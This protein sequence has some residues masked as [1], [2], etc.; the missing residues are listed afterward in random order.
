MKTPLHVLVAE[1]E[2]GDVL[3][4]ERAFAKAGV[5]APV[6]VAADGQEVLD[7][8]EGVPPFNNPV[9]YPL[10]DLLLLDLHLPRVNGF[11]VLTRIR[12]HP[13]LSQ[14]LVVILSSSN[15]PEEIQRA[16]ALG[17]NSYIVKPQDPTE[18]VEVVRGLQEHWQRI[19][20]SDGFMPGH[21]SEVVQHLTFGRAADLAA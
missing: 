9:Q 8:L 17:A 13:K 19:N 16:G 2:I 11:E 18:L 1:D 7:Y 15:H 6:Y 4:L 14:M 3:L 5:S 21:E 20:A 10:P 12:N